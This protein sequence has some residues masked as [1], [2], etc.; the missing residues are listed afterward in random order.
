M[1]RD[2]EK[3]AMPRLQKKTGFMQAEGGMEVT[4]IAERVETTI[5]K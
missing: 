4:K 3:G 1:Q 5:T 2:F